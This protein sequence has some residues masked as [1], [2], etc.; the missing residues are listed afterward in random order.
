VETRDRKPR[1][2]WH[3]RGCPKCGAESPA[4]ILYGL[5]AFTPELKAKLKAGKIVLG[6]CLVEEGQPTWHCNACDHEW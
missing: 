3:Q 5:P 4:W 2:G 6:G 1:G